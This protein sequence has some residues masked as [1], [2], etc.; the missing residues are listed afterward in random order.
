MNIEKALI[1]KARADAYPDA[2]PN[3]KVEP[4]DNRQLYHCE[5]CYFTVW[6]PPQA[7]DYLRECEQYKETTIFS[8]ETNGET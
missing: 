6:L 2:F 7:F 3:S 8:K 5:N 1:W 4:S